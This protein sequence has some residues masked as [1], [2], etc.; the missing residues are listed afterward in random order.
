MA[1]DL[2]TYIGDGVYVIFDG[3]GFWLHA[4]DLRNPTDK[5]YLE[6]AVFY[7]LVAAVKRFTDTTETDDSET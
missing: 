6:P 2:S 3:Y 7:D 4:N 1:D 5:I